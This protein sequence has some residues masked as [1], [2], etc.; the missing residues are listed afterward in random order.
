MKTKWTT[1]K[2]HNHPVFWGCDCGTCKQ[3]SS[4][5]LRAEGRAGTWSELSALRASV[6]RKFNRGRISR[7]DIDVY[8]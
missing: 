5:F 4:E 7:E 2:M 1:F 6:V 8:C 3:I